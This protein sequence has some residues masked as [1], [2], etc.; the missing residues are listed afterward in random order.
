MRTIAP[1]SHVRT[2]AA[3]LAACAAGTAAVVAVAPA[4]SAS[5]IIYPAALTDSFYASPGD[6]ADHR[7]GDVLATRPVSA[8]AGFLN[9]DAVQLK[10]RST[11]SEGQPIAAVTT[12]LSPRGAAPGRPL[13]SYQHIINA[14][15]L[16]CA[17]STAMYTD[18]PKL[19]IREAPGLNVA[20]AKGWSVAIPDHL[21]PPRAYGAAKLGGQITLD[22]IRAARRFDALGLGASP[23]G[24][25]GYSGG[26]MATAMAAAIAPTYA[27]E[28]ELAG[29]AY[30]GA[31]MNID[32]M[33]KALGQQKHPAFGLAMAAALGLE[34][35]YPDRMPITS[36][37]NS[38]GQQ[39]RDQIANAAAN[40]IMFL[41]RRPIPRRCRGS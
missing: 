20:I 30:G 17:P 40:E 22:G 14:L 10:F 25:A 21:G 23:V 26:G 8:P 36:Q 13:L 5:P 11:N 3:L 29:S 24:M 38:A 12:V 27:P 31:P 33:A 6:L 4:A 28:L 41:R 37:L 9:T 19:A 35:E 18:D 2:I 7:P 32:K 34:R 39:L 1:R 16:G 15:G